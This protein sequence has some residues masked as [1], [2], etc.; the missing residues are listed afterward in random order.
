VDASWPSSPK[1]IDDDPDPD[2]RAELTALLE[3]GD[4]AELRDRFSVRSRSGPPACAGACAR[5]R[6]G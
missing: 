1:L 5:A 4:E 3:A 6:T 2:A